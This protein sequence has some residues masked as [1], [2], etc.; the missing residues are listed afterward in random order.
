MRTRH[1]V[2]CTVPQILEA[3][4]D[5]GCRMILRGGNVDNLRDTMGNYI[6]HVRTRFPFTEKICFAVHV[7]IVS[8]DIP[9]TVFDTNDGNSARY[10]S[11]IPA[12]V[13]L[14]RRRDPD[15]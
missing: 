10:E 6:S 7:Q 8:R 4:G 9:Y 2:E 14:E 12:N 1:V 11:L 15:D 3:S 5:A 13:D